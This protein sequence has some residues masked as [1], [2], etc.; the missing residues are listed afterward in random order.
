[1][2]AP[3]QQG[4]PVIQI[5]ENF[6]RPILAAGGSEVEF[7]GEAVM[8]AE[9]VKKRKMSHPGA[10]SDAFVA[11]EV[12]FADHVGAS[13]SGFPRVLLLMSN[14]LFPGHWHGLW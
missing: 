4:N 5:Q 6:D 7:A 10:V 1:M 13:L 12:A 14:V 3:S 8:H 11:G 9:R 2:A